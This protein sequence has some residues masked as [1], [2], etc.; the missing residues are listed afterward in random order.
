MSKAMFS[1]I[2][3]ILFLTTVLLIT[4]VM[5]TWRYY[6]QEHGPVRD[7]EK[8][9]LIIM[10][11]FKYNDPG[12]VLPGGPGTV[13]TTP[14]ETTTEPPEESN[15]DE[16]EPSD[17]DETTPEE[18]TPEETT[19]SEPP[20]PVVE[21]GENHYN[22]VQFVTG[23]VGEEGLNIVGGIIYRFVN[24]TVGP[25]YSEDNTTAGGNL[26]KEFE[27]YNAENLEFIITFDRK[28]NPTVCYTYTYKHIDQYDNDAVEGTYVVV[29]KTIIEPIGTD[30]RWVATR[31]YKGYAIVGDPSNKKVTW[32]P[33]VEKW[34]EGEIPQ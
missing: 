24:K 3:I 25:E 27:K 19:P 10:N 4:P 29:Y 31:S 9:A 14:A 12:S 16:T 8:N 26:P 30:G 11:Q 21:D 22:L 23:D 34:I 32:A 1:K 18:T 6:D 5:A 17:P 13:V 33:L 7:V 15:P 20:P 28:N 2:G